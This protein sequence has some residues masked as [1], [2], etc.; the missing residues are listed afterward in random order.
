ML[1]GFGLGEELPG[2]VNAKLGESGVSPEPP[3][4][5]MYPDTPM[6]ATQRIKTT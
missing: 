1:G 2:D 3:K 6:A 4:N 5:S